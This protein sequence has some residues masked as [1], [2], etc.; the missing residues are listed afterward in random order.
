MVHTQQ[1][2]GSDRRRVTRHPLPQRYWLARSWQQTILIKWRGGR[3][4]NGSGA[5]SAVSDYLIYNMW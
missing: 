1:M 2:S 4:Y 3:R 5:K